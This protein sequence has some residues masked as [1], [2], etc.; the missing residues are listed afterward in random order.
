MLLSHAMVLGV[1]QG[2][3][4]FL[5]I[6]SSAH[7]ILVP[8]F[9]HFA[10]PGLLVDVALHVG[11][12]LALCFF[13]WRT[14]YRIIVDGLLRGDKHARHL[15]WIILIASIPGVFAGIVLEKA[16]ENAFRQPLLIAGTLFVGGVILWWADRRPTPRV[17]T[18]SLS[19]RD[20]LLVGLAQATALVPGI[21]R[22]GAT[23]SAARALGFDR[24]TAAEL[25]FLL[26]MPITAGAA[27]LAL[28]HVGS[29]DLTPA[30][31]IGI[32]VSALVGGCA[33]R[34]LLAYVKRATLQVFVWYRFVLALAILCYWYVI[35]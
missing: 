32:L 15:L 25:S 35:R 7:L 6:S 22:S 29:T 19:F 17:G 2:L 16:A 27:L 21:S 20:A 24:S 33:I 34:F 8:W 30:F 11:T 28:R 9:F 3:A 10:D 26:A 14:W 18:P 12:L 1:V 13:F 23:I 5:P 4:E 31:F